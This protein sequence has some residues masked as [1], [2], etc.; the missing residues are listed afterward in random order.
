MLCC[1]VGLWLLVPTVTCAWRHSS[2]PQQQIVGA[3][4]L[5]HDAGLWTCLQSGEASE[6]SPCSW[7]SLW[8]HIISRRL[9]PTFGAFCKPSRDVAPPVRHP[10]VAIQHLYDV[11]HA[12]M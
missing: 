6:S 1:Q 4:Q 10:A 12:G 7:V 3:E 9:Q 8:D 11:C 2:A 5:Y